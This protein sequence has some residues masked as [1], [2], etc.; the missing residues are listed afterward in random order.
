MFE[1][2]TAALGLKHKQDQEPAQ[3]INL[4]DAV[5]A[6]SAWKKR[7]LDYVEG[8]SKEDLQPDKIRADNLCVLGKWIQGDGKVQFGEQPV[9]IRLV[10]EHAK[11]HHHASLVVEAHRNGDTRLALEILASSFDEQSRKTVNCLAKLNAIVGA[12]NQALELQ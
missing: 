11:F 8:C 10:E 9:F 3:V 12:R 2:F 4:Y 6:H 7:L 5:L 1:N